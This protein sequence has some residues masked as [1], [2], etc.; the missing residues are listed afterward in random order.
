MKYLTQAAITVETYSNM[1]DST[2]TKTL[3]EFKLQ[4]I[5]VK[6]VDPSSRV[7]Y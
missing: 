5:N 6:N 1:S 7:I 3:P 4:S 2:L